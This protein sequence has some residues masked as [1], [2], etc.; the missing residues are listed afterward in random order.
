MKDQIIKFLNEENISA[1]K[2]ADDIG[3]QRSSISH[4]LSG[5]NKPS[6]DFIEKMLEKYPKISADWLIT[7]KG[8]MYKPIQNDKKI[9]LQEYNN[10]PDL[11]TS[12]NKMDKDNSSDKDQ[13]LTNKP[14]LEDS[15]I[16]TSQFTN[17]NK[18]E[19]IVFF[20]TS[21]EFKEYIPSEF[22]I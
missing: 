12:I 2:L 1:T 13:R 5:R 21:G 9:K 16:K 10:E 18:V 17:V 14:P 20:Y 4:I 19:K 22:K 6:Y 3:V 15:E 11:F 8:N 7:G